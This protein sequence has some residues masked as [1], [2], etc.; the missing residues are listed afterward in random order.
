VQ[1][2]P[3]GQ[4]LRAGPGPSRRR[5]IASRA[6]INGAEQQQQQQQ[7][8]QQDQQQQDQQQQDQQQQDQQQQEEQQQQAEQQQQQQNE[9]DL[10]D[11]TKESWADQMDEDEN[12]KDLD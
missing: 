10:P 11:R 6:A 8:Q 2:L 5:R 4:R 12:S 9:S 3:A 1:D 7:Q